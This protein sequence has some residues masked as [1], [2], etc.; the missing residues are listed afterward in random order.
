MS[1]AQLQTDASIQPE[2]DSVGGSGI[3]DSGLYNSV[4]KMAYLGESAGGA[5]S[6]TLILETESNGEFKTVIY[7]TTRKDNGQRNTFE[8][9][10]QRHYLPSF[11]LGSSVCM[12][13]VNKPI[14]EV[15]TEDKIVKIWD[16]AAGKEM[17]TNVPVLTA[18]IGQP[19]IAGIYKKNV[20]KEKNVA[21][22]GSRAKYVATGETRDEN[23]VDKFFRAAD[24]LTT[25][26]ILAGSTESAFRDTW[27]TKNTG[28]TRMKAKGVAEAVTQSAAALSESTAKPVKSIFG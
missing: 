1:L 10:G 23:E 3:L 15:E 21:P 6:L 20:D 26:E 14:G 16:K 8:K 13:T 28:V 17:P 19:I 4:I 9:N 18:L 22:E 2:T 5:I 27:R 11:N 24:G 12:L 25:T 7:L